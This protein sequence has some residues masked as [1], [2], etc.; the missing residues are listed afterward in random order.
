[1]VVDNH[2]PQML[3]LPGASGLAFRNMAL[4]RLEGCLGLFHQAVLAAFANP[5]QRLKVRY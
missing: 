4:R 5:N 1:V 2:L 3:G